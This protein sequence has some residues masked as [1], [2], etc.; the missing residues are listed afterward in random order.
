MR[1]TFGRQLK[2][3]QKYRWPLKNTNS[4]SM[5]VLLAFITVFPLFSQTASQPPAS[6]SQA[7]TSGPTAGIASNHPIPLP[8]KYRY[9]LIYQMKL[10]RKADALEQQGHPEE[11][12]AAR[13]H[14]QKD[15]GFADE[16][17][18]IVR[19]TGLQLKSDL[20]AIMSQAKPIITTDRQWLKLH[21]RSAGPPPGADQIHA[22]QAQ[23]ETAMKD[24]VIHLNQQLGPV[25][26]AR[27]QAY[28]DTHVVG[29]A[30][31]FASHTP[32]KA[33]PFHL[34]AQQ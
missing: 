29:H 31:H 17:I 32:R 5:L 28:I 6:A 13:N 18:A 26:A 12:A 8:H 21:G 34:E 1:V 14:L 9:F 10:D 23:Q 15:L 16:Q 4:H 25:P 11:A 7:Q 24:A 33:T 22:L 20:D 3:L 19:E 2:S 30:T 27:L